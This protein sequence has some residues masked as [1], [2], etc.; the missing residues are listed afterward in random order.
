MYFNIKVITNVIF[1][2]NNVF[3]N[4]VFLVKIYELSMNFYNNNQYIFFK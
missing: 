4:L 3:A 2:L 1:S